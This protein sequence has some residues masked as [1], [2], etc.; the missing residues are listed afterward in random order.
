MRS[1]IQEK[2][3]ISDRRFY[4]FL[5]SDNKSLP[6]LVTGCDVEFLGNKFVSG[7]HCFLSK[8]SDGIVWLEDARFA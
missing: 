6:P 1:F 8:D 2:I 7:H 4:V 3:E 5:L